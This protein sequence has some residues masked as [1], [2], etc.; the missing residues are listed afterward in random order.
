MPV[1]LRNGVKNS[2][3]GS[4]RPLASPQ[5]AEFTQSKEERTLTL[6]EVTEGLCFFL[7]RLLG[8]RGVEF[9]VSANN[10]HI[11]GSSHPTSGQKQ[12]T[13]NNSCFPK[14]RFWTRGSWRTCRLPCRR[15]WGRVTHLPAKSS[16]LT[17]VFPSFNTI[18]RSL[19]VLA[20]ASYCCQL[21]SL[22]YSEHRLHSWSR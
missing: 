15:P 19:A 18:C 21:R 20:S 1:E 10:D 8:S 13:F 9:F 4:E 2:C 7:T 16:T 17:D 6:S 3:L 11:C 5:P 12:H 22:I 14:C